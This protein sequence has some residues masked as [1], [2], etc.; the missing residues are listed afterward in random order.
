MVDDPEFVLGEAHVGD[1]AETEESGTVTFTGNSDEPVKT[2]KKELFL[3]YTDE[4]ATEILEL[5]V[6]KN[7]EGLFEKGTVESKTIGGFSELLNKM[8]EENAKKIQE[9]RRFEKE[10]GRAD[11]EHR[12]PRIERRV[13]TICDVLLAFLREFF[14][15]YLKYRPYPGNPKSP[16]SLGQ[17]QHSSIIYFT[18][19]EA[20]RNRAI[21]LAK[22]KTLFNE[23]KPFY[24]QD[25]VLEEL[26]FSRIFRPD[27][28]A[29]K[30]I[31]KIQGGLTIENIAF[32][33]KKNGDVVY[34]GWYNVELD[35]WSHKGP[36]KP[37]Q[38]ALQ[39]A[40][41]QYSDLITTTINRD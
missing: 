25:Y 24:G 17:Y 27:G 38:L 31:K 28:D 6:Q 11:K 36:H 41:S 8:L 3:Y 22:A 33:K 13:K 35:G 7:L 2:R 9:G 23:D 20:S 18:K 1:D 29:D 4:Q 19:D 39:H 10:T 34:Y 32:K 15:A 5:Y 14:R 30:R 37:F 26:K 21:G 16:K 12:R 40:Q